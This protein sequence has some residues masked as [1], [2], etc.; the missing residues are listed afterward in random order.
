MRN[1]LPII[2]GFLIGGAVGFVLLYF[3][4]ES[5][6]NFILIPVNSTA[7]FLRRIFMPN[8]DPMAA[9]LLVIPLVILYCAM[10]GSIL[11][12]IVQVMIAGFRKDNDEK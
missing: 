12:A 11:G 3:P 6:P 10:L 5:I 8:T 7:C 9:F 4:V 1:W 2:I